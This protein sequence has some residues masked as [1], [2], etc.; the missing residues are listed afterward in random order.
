MKITKK[1]KSNCAKLVL[2]VLYT[3]YYIVT[4]IPIHFFCEKQ[5]C[6]TIKTKDRKYVLDM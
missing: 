3:S 4:L 6:K 1:S 5:L 2:V